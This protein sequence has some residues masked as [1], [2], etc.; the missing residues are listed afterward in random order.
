MQAYSKNTV[1]KW[2]WKK[3]EV[4]QIFEMYCGQCAK[5]HDRE[6]VLEGNQL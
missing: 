5:L 1:L 6:N 3:T 4:V 2:Y